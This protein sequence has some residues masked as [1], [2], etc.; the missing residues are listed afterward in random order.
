MT[1]RSTA[2]SPAN[3]ALRHA[4]ATISSEPVLESKADPEAVVEVALLVPPG[5]PGEAPG[6]PGPVH[7][8]EGNA[9]GVRHLYDAGGDGLGLFAEADDERDAV[10]IAVVA[11]EAQQVAEVRVVD[12][13]NLG[14]VERIAEAPGVDVLLDGRR[15]RVDVGRRVPRVAIAQAQA[16]GVRQL[17]A[18]LQRHAPLGQDLRIGRGVGRDSVRPVVVQAVGVAGENLLVAGVEAL[19]EAQAAE[20]MALRVEPPVETE[21][22]AFPRRP[23]AG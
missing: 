12:V 6:G 16:P 2:P 11:V 19:F 8:G 15:E 3:W 21:R 23:A 1:S 13:G 17:A 14:S 9:P 20:E 7:A 18:G 5:V 22:C 10:R 4:S